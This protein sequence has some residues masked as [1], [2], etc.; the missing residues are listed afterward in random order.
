MPV[1]VWADVAT[2]LTLKGKL[3][4]PVTDSLKVAVAVMTWPAPYVPAA[5]LSMARL[6]MLGA[7]ASTRIA[8]A[9]G[10]VLWVPTLLVMRTCTLYILSVSEA[11]V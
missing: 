3:A 10:V 7:V 1:Q 9:K 2:P 11:G 6:T 4:V 8:L 5:G